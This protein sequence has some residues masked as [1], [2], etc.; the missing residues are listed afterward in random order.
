MKPDSHV[1]TRRGYLGRNGF[2]GKVWATKFENGDVKSCFTEEEVHNDLLDSRV[3]G[4]DPSLIDYIN[5]FT[6]VCKEKLQHLSFIR[7]R[8]VQAKGNSERKFDETDY[9]FLEN[10]DSKNSFVKSGNGSEVLSVKSNK[11]RNRKKKN[12]LGEESSMADYFNTKQNHQLLDNVRLYPIFTNEE[13]PQ[14]QVESFKRFY[15]VFMKDEL[16]ELVQNVRTLKILT[17]YYD[18]GNWVVKAE[19]KGLQQA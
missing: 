15:H 19:K 13:S 9:K 1:C 17:H 6:A 18:H 3:Q 11:I 14:F 5:D 12:E 10:C 4:D 8:N 7:T 16:S 2:L